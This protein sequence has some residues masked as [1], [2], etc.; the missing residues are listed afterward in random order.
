MDTRPWTVVYISPN[1]SRA[2]FTK[3]DMASAIDKIADL[4]RVP[5]KVTINRV[6]SHAYLVSARPDQHAF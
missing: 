6:G 2:K 3:S 1:G 4:M 5:H